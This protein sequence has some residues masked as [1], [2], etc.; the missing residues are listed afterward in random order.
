M[1]L[2]GFSVRTDMGRRD[3]TITRDI[4]DSAIHLERID[5][6]LQAVIFLNKNGI[7]FDTIKR[8]LLA[9]GPMRRPV[10]SADGTPRARLPVAQSSRRTAH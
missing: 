4:I 9:A 6:V 5:G 1:E 7:D 8:I 10:E 2:A 3:D